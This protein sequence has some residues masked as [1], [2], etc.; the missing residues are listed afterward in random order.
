MS[1]EA[2]GSNRLGNVTAVASDSQDA[3]AETAPPKLTSATVEQLHEIF[4]DLDTNHNGL[5][6]AAE[7]QVRSLTP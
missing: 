3:K 1:V 4:E 7:L 5:L 2:V 6:D